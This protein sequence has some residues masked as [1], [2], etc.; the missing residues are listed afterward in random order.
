LYYLQLIKG[1]E[2][3]RKYFYILNYAKNRNFNFAILSMNNIKYL[4]EKYFIDSQKFPIQNLSNIS[5]TVFK[6]LLI[7]YNLEKGVF[8]RE[9]DKIITV[10]PDVKGIELLW[11]I[12]FDCL[13]Q[14]VR[15][16]SG[17][18]LINIYSC[19]GSHFMEKMPA[20]AR[21]FLIFAL[22]NAEKIPDN[23]ERVMMAIK[24]IKN[25]IKESE[26]TKCG[27]ID[28]NVYFSEPIIL[29]KV[30]IQRASRSDQLA[31]IKINK[32]LT[33][34]HLKNM[35]SCGLKIP[36]SRLR[37]KYCAKNVYL[38]ELQHD[39]EILKDLI[40]SQNDS[41]SIQF[42]IE[43]LKSEI[44]KEKTPSYT[45]ANFER[46]KSKLI[47]L[48]KLDEKFA[49]EI[50]KLIKGFPED[51]TLFRTL[52]NLELPTGKTI[53]SWSIFLAPGNDLH[54][55][56]YNLHALR[57]ILTNTH[58]ANIIVPPNYQENIIK[59]GIFTFLILKYSEFSNEIANKNFIMSYTKIR[60]LKY[61]LRIFM[62]LFNSYFFLK[63]I[64]NRQANEKIILTEEQI[65]ELIKTPLNFL[66]YFLI[67][68]ENITQND[69]YKILL[70]KTVKSTFNL[71]NKIGLI[72]S[73]K[74]KEELTK[75][76]TLYEI[77]KSCIFLIHFMMSK[78][79]QN[80]RI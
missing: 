4:F 13:D 34:F 9:K 15:E 16:Q 80:S 37:I 59:K 66:Q 56:L 27:K 33:V 44:P 31:T 26:G 69:D 11:L 25:Y 17:K 8:K 48:M 64:I 5:Y 23:K 12:T 35:L 28:R 67:T 70:N 65:I 1:A 22:D 32:N 58:Q 21:S 24:L 18:F 78:Y 68:C 60:L 63:I 51:T 29:F 79:I 53:V 76:D 6:T 41:Q 54:V 43:E 71:F 73:E 7:T 46:G 61:I 52:T 50:W 55:L 45:I 36:L 30:K 19:L 42:I 3:I 77:L 49:E 39:K 74:I 10:N 57:I 14:E 20:V 62:I 38:T 72:Y 47:K 2:K 75:N 40:N